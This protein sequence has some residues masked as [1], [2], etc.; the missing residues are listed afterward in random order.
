MLGK[1]SGEQLWP[2]IVAMQNLWM[3]YQ[4]ISVPNKNMEE[5]ANEQAELLLGF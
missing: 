1:G 5:T 4:E 2:L 3:F